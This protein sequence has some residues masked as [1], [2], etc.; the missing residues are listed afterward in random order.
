MPHYVCLITSPHGT[1]LQ[2]FIY[3]QRALKVSHGLR[4]FFTMHNL[5]VI[6]LKLFR[7][8]PTTL[9]IIYLGLYP[10]IVY[11]LDGRGWAYISI[12][13]DIY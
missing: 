7:T 3:N 1:Q 5:E 13:I 6:T 9:A 10:V 11:N 2:R 4:V 8:I 12:L